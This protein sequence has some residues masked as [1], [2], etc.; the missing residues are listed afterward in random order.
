[1]L[2]RR[3]LIAATAGT[4]AAP[5]IARAQ[6]QAARSY[7]L[8]TATIGGT[9]YP[10]GVALATLTKIRLQAARGIDMSAISSAGS[11]ENIRLMR[12]GQAQFAILQGLFGVYARDGSG[13]IQAEGPQRNIRAIANLWANVEHFTIRARFAQTG[14]IDDIL[15]IRGRR[16]SMSA[17]NSGTEFS[18]R[19]IFANLGIDPERTFELVY[20][21]FGPSAEAMLAG[22]IDGFNPGGGVPVAAITQLFA[23]GGNEFRILEFTDEQLKKADGGTGLFTRFVIPGGTYPNLA[24]PI[25][26]IAQPNFLAVNANVPADDVYEITKAIFE[27]LPFL[28]GIHAATREISLENA[29]KGIVN[30][31]HP[32]AAR[33]YA[34]KG[35]TIPEAIRP[36]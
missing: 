25:N 28:N 7:I 32:G 24:Q 27:N 5:A 21:G 19:F 20:Q 13:P 36:V 9:Y 31:V 23:R 4:L 1:M 6:A 2:S 34:E 10:V 12:E 29:L 11:G 14:T 3:T 8:A 17:R 16:F 33:Y 26:T 18:N 22:Q 35:V 30:P 15:N